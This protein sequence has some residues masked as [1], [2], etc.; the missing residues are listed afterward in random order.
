MNWK[1]EAIEKLEQYQARKQSLRIIPAEIARLEAAASAMRSMSFDKPNVKRTASSAEDVLLSNLMK[2]DA[3][4]QSL[5]QAERWVDIVESGLDV[6][7]SEERM[8]LERFYIC[9]EKGA[10]DRLAGD[11]AMDVKTVYR[12]KD[13]ALRRFT[14][15]LCGCVES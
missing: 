8:I 3:L 15:A 9:G 11:L 10:A 1:E 5:E 12:R 2:R 14:I 13:A 6:L 4:Q 7:N